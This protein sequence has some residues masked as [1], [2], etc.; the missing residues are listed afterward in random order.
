M[1]LDHHHDSLV[2]T[3]RQLASSGK[4]L[5]AADESTC[6]IGKCFQPIGVENSEENRRAHRSLLATAAGLGEFISGV[7]LSRA[8]ANSQ[9]SRGCYLSG[10]RLLDHMAC[11]QG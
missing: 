2:A 7:I 1:A 5:L 4:G 3:A 11:R 10:R 6:T 9:A 8:R